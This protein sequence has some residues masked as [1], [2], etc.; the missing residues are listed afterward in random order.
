MDG[1]SDVTIEEAK[2]WDNEILIDNFVTH[3]A[4]MMKDKNATSKIGYSLWLKRHHIM[5]NEIRRRMK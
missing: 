5:L 1:L 4:S 2:S 3:F